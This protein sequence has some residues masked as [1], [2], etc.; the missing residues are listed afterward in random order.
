MESVGKARYIFDDVSVQKPVLHASRYPWAQCIGLF[1]GKVGEKETHV[2]D[3]VPLFH[4][5]VFS[6]MLN[7]AYKFVSFGCSQ[8]PV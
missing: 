4:T 1:L 3:C 8:D 2:V 6:P 7:I 5:V